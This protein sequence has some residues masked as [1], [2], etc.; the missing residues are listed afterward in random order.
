[1]VII[2][3]LMEEFVAQ[4]PT[5]P[6]RSMCLAH[7]AN[8]TAKKSDNNIRPTVLL[9]LPEPFESPQITIFQTN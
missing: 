4:P 5:S 6:D 1:M 7:P 8:K 2:E 3:D 9:D